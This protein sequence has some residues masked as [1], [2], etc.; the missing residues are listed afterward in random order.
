MS[1]TLSLS[2]FFLQSAKEQLGFLTLNPGHYVGYFDD[3]I[4][5]PFF[6]FDIDSVPDS[7]QAFWNAYCVIKRI[8]Y[9][10]M[11]SRDSQHD[12]QTTGTQYMDSVRS[13]I[14]LFLANPQRAKFLRT[15]SMYYAL[16][17]LS[18]ND[19]SQQS[20]DKQIF[21]QIA[22]ALFNEHVVRKDL[23]FSKLSTYLV[24]H[25]ETLENYIQAM[26][27]QALTDS[28]RFYTQQ[29]FHHKKSK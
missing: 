24:R 12:S 18:E 3:G 5:S 6:D 14:Q 4:I 28:A 13:A 26:G 27:D 11:F 16:K 1:D 29:R 23:L 19:N 10:K 22:T 20:S 17:F 21:D 15:S 25:S 2:G 9:D 7:L 8:N